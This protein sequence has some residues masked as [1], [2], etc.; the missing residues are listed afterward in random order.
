MIVYSPEASWWPYH[1][2]KNTSSRRYIHCPSN[3]FA[4]FD[5]VFEMITVRVFN[6][7]AGQASI[8]QY[9]HYHHL[10]LP[11]FSIMI[12]HHE[13][14]PS[15]FIIV[16][17]I[18]IIPR[19]SSLFIIVRHHHHPFII[20]IIIATNMIHW[21]AFNMILTTHRYHHQC[22]LKNYHVQFTS[23]NR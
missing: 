22:F 11:I 9:L 10:V 5:S 19:C 3:A 17:I 13:H 16:I 6:D 20:F 18:I 23:S 4:L 7:S 14:S 2:E 8:S 21:L 1:V 15:S 12:I